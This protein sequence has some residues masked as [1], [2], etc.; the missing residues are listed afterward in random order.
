[1]SIDEDA[2]WQEIEKAVARALQAFV[3]P[4]FAKGSF[5]D[6]QSLR[7]EIRAIR[8]SV[9]RTQ[10]QIMEAVSDA[11]AKMQAEADR[12]VA[13]ILER[14]TQIPDGAPTQ[15][16]GR[17]TVPSYADE[18][19]DRVAPGPVAQNRQKPARATQRTWANV[20]GTG[21]PT[22]VGWTTVTNGK[23]KL[24]KHPLEQRRIL[25]A[26]NVQTHTCD[27]R[28][29]MFEV[30][31][32]LAHARAHV[33]VRLIKMRYT[34][35]GNLTGLLNETARVEDLLEYAPAVNS[36]VCIINQFKFQGPDLIDCQG[37]FRLID[38]L[39]HIDQLD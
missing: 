2:L 28:D 24:Q 32:A 38:C 39:L 4:D 9:D 26:R 10:M 6:V 5:G 22:A 14:L 13:S 21:A 1:M 23:R 34:E 31:K 29:L 36:E 15:D 30:N 20:V 19:P 11:V 17:D 18:R 27:P 25:F 7:S 12:R 37:F 8:E 33:T 3:G 16:K 35:K